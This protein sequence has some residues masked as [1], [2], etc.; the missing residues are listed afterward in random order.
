MI[1]SAWRVH[2]SPTLFLEWSWQRF[3]DS[4]QKLWALVMSSVVTSLDN[5]LVMWMEL[6]GWE[7]RCMLLVPSFL[8]L[9]YLDC[10]R[11]SHGD[12][13]N[14][15]HHSILKS[16]A[17][18]CVAVKLK[19]K[20]WRFRQWSQHEYDNIRCLRFSRIVS[21]F[22]VWNLYAHR[23]TLGSEGFMLVVWTSQRFSLLGYNC[24]SS[25]FKSEK[26]N[27]LCLREGVACWE[28]EYR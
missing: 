27:T 24:P 8:L 12:D 6:L 20:G 22:E 18:A 26:K 21:T 3:Q 19:E 25:R 7:Q 14:E 10:R 4:L 23:Q 1:S 13:S 17:A 2:R 16:Q 11:W 5:R 15:K 9:E 28:H